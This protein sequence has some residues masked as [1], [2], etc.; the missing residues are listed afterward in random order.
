MALFILNA[1]SSR[2]RDRSDSDDSSRER[3]KK[4]G[5]HRRSKSKSPNEKKSSRSKRRSSR[6]G[7]KD[8]ENGDDRA[9]NQSKEGS[10]AKAE[11]NN[12]EDNENK[13]GD[14]NDRRVREK[15]NF[16]FSEFIESF[17]FRNLP[18]ENPMKMKVTEVTMKVTVAI[19]RKVN[20]E[21]QVMKIWMIKLE[22]NPIIQISK[23]VIKIK[24]KPTTT[25]KDFPMFA[26]LIR[27]LMY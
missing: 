21:I 5:K 19:R 26:V 17:F 22:M 24:R 18:V 7:S 25:K 13:S 8:N 9:S 23:V 12:D 11:R 4:S 6:S 2:S 14:E 10:P 20:V 16:F 3:D 15:R 27:T 1:L